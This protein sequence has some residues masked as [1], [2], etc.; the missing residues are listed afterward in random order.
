[1][2]IT[3]KQLEI[4]LEVAK[5]GNMTQASEVLH[6]TQSACSMALSALEKQLGDPL[7][8]RHG[9]KLI[10]NERGR[11]LFPKAS[12]IISQVKESEA[13]MLGKKGKMLAGNLII[14]ASTT[15]GNY[16]LP[17]IIGSFAASIHKQK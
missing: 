4:F 11:I 16:V 12:N 3:L 5:T 6:L 9:K 2:H 17:K 10:L 15:L 8:D 7:F 13:L 1:M 14:G